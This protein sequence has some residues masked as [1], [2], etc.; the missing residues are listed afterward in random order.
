M[1]VA[2]NNFDGGDDI[3]MFEKKYNFINLLEVK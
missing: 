1:R 2:C 3:S